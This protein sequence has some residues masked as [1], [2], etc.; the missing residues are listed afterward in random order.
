MKKIVIIVLA[1]FATSVFSQS[2]QQAKT[3]LNEVSKKVTS[4]N[5]IA[6]KFDYVLDNQKENIHQKTTGSVNIQGEKYHLKFMGIDRIY[7]TNKVY[8]IVHEDEEVVIANPDNDH[9]NNFTPSKLLTFYKKG[10]SFKWDTQKTIAGKKIQFIKLIPKNANA[11]NKYILL[12]IDLKTKNIQQVVYLNNNNTKTSFII[13]DF[14]T[15]IKLPKDE[16]T[17]NEAKYKAKDFVITRL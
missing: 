15:N 8:T 5:N 4:Y 12:G 3:L 14:N 13:L 2:N 6:L 7:D 11:E 1:L 9:E 16:F 17:F 10:Y